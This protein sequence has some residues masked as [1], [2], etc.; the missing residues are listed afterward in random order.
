M[1]LLYVGI[2]STYYKGWIVLKKWFHL[3]GGLLKMFDFLERFKKSC[4]LTNQSKN[5]WD[6][7]SDVLKRKQIT[8]IPK[9]GPWSSVGKS[10]VT[11][12]NRNSNKRSRNSFFLT[13]CHTHFCMK[14]LPIGCCPP[15]CRYSKLPEFVNLSI[16]S[17]IRTS[18][19]QRWLVLAYQAT[20]VLPPAPG[21][22]YL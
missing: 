21:P 22:V 13:P 10:C 20:W 16:L 5:F 17:S 15:I 1:H 18:D 11:H 2:P 8:L 6:L 19:R 3:K 14:N 12:Q 4:F 7:L 9:D